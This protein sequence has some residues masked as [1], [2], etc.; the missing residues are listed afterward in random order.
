[1]F[2]EEI[3]TCS[4]Y[5]DIPEHI[6]RQRD[7]MR[8][9]LES[10]YKQGGPIEYY[11]GI[12]EPEKKEKFDPLAMVTIS[13]DKKPTIEQ[14]LQHLIEVQIDLTNSLTDVAMSNYAL[15]EAMAGEEPDE[16]EERRYQTLG[17]EEP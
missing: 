6:K 11:H 7:E 13:D 10:Q 16:D 17:G 15:V 8:D 14:L 9:M 12:A 4:Y 2:T 5:C 3:H 1:M